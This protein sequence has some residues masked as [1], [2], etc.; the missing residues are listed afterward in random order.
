[1]TA[2]RITKGD[3]IALRGEVSL[4][5]QRPSGVRRIVVRNT[6]TYVGLNALLA[7]LAQA[8]TTPGDYAMRTLVPGTNGTPPTPGDLSLGA[9]LG[10]PDQITLSAP[11]FSHNTATRELIVTGTLSTSQGNGST[12]REIGLALDN[13]DLFARQVHPGVEKDGSMSITYSWRFG[14]TA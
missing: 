9:P 8:G 10:A 12:L 2:K 7:L 3:R 6:I 13:G 14:V 1:M 5:I 11:N 4:I